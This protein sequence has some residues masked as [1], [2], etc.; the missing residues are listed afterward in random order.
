MKKM[1]FLTALLLLIGI[2]FSA[3]PYTATIG[4]PLTEY[5]K[6]EDVAA[7]GFITHMSGEDF[8]SLSDFSIKI[9]DPTLGPSDSYVI[10]AT[11]DNFEFY[12]DYSNSGDLVVSGTFV[13]RFNTDS[14]VLTDGKEYD[15][16][17]FFKDEMLAMTSFKYVENVQRSGTTSAL[18]YFGLS[19]LVVPVTVTGTAG[20]TYTVG[21]YMPLPED[22]DRKITDA[23][24][25]L[26]GDSDSTVFEVSKSYL[27]DGPTVVVAKADD[28]VNDATPTVFVVG[29]LDPKSITFQGSLE[30][31]DCVA[32]ENEERTC[33]I[34]VINN[35]E[36][37]AKYS[38]DV[39]STLDISVE[40]P[41]QEVQP[42]DSIE[43][44]MT[45]SA[46]EGDAP[47]QVATFNLKSG[48]T[49]LDTVS[50]TINVEPRDLVDEVSLKVTSVSPAVAHPGDEVNIDVNVENTGDFGSMVLVQYKIDDESY[51][52][53]G[54]LINLEPGDSRR[55]T[56]R[57]NAPEESSIVS[58]RVVEDGE[59]KDEV[60][61]AIR[62]EPYVYTPY[63]RWD[64]GY[65]YVTQGNSSTNV[66]KVRNEGNTG[67]FYEIDIDSQFASLHKRIYFEPG[68]EKEFEIPIVVRD[69]AKPGIYDI[70][71]TVCAI[72]GKSC[73]S[74]SFELT[75]I[76]KEVRNTTVVATNEVEVED[77]ESPI[78]KIEVV[79]NEG[80]SGTYTIGIGNFD[81]EYK[82][83]PE[84]MVLLDG[85]NGTFFLMAQPSDKV[86][87]NITYTVFMDGNAV[88][89]GNLTAIYP[90]S[91]LSGLITLSKSGSIGAIIL[92]TI[93]IA[94]LTYFGVRS[95]NQSKVELK[96]WK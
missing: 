29:A 59:I 23:T 54:G 93:L 46:K 5:G 94:G 72:D 63:L 77:D 38:V 75:V 40:L 73:E 51:V 52:S 88:A 83:T 96:Y 79:N 58:I 22:M 26:N 10:R 7:Y 8:Y 53:L 32:K 43:G 21:L 48:D 2:G 86:T 61:H 45:I 20:N 31:G 24:L 11:G 82:V 85:E 91:M 6:G 47:Y 27:R 65:R 34:T 76:E 87:Q 37:P 12:S 30:I 64:Y 49:V 44:T 13:V 90:G 95:F 4:T 74:E 3:Q 33:K 25:T 28:G 19:D 17:L 39:S 15:V 62:V 66:L 69:N 1:A 14:F 70:D 57:L 35:G 36:Y 18:Y 89:R 16:A 84:S 92:G 67:T 68:D 56:I 60:I 50:E 78:F 80:R 9:F 71:A 81:G 42:G 55:L 41:D